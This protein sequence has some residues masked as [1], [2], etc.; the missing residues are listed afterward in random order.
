M[1]PNI[2]PGNYHLSSHSHGLLGRPWGLGHHIRWMSTKC[3]PL[4]PKHYALVNQLVALLIVLANYPL[5]LALRN[6]FS[7][8]NPRFLLF[9]PRREQLPAPF[10]SPLDILLHIPLEYLLPREFIVQG[11][12]LRWG[13]H[14]RR[15]YPLLSFC[16]PIL[17]VIPHL[18]NHTVIIIPILYPHLKELFLDV[19]Q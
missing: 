7:L 16:V 19:R 9:Y 8:I 5:L 6:G 1:A 3:L 12:S 4:W 14:L 11:Q 13:F 10:K 17:R 15:E 2:E 18:L